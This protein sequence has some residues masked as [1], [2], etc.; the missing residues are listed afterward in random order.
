MNF[1]PDLV[2]NKEVFKAFESNVICSI[3]N[4]III[5]PIQCLAC[6]NSFCESCLKSWIKKKGNECPFRCNNPFFKNSRIVKNLL[7]NL[8]FKCANGCNTEILYKDLEEH[9]KEKCPKIDFKQKY[10]EYKKKYEDILIKYKELEK[11]KQNQNLTFGA[12]GI[13]S[14][15]KSRF[16]IHILYDNT[17]NEADWIC[18]ICKGHYINKTEGRFRCDPCDFD[19]CL[20]C[21]LLEES[22]YKF[23]NLF[24]SQFHQHYLNEQTFF[25]GNW[26]CKICNRI[27]QNT[28]KR[29]I[30]ICCDYSICI[31]CKNKEQLSSNFNNFTFH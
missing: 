16:H 26:T 25:K 15:F 22:G 31:D 27:L 29:F 2:V 28:L 13:N 7:E 11:N 4:G 17:N 9:Y 8:K 3:C 20:K 19:I 18:N 1:D 6:E 21:K 12:Q 24:L 30:C 23:D 14:E 10:L 5:N